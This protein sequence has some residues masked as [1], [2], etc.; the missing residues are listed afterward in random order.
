MTAE[1]RGSSGYGHE[2]A[3]RKLLF[4]R[5]HLLDAARVEME[6]FPASALPSEVTGN[7][8]ADNISIRLR[9][10][11]SLNPPAISPQLLVQPICA[12]LV[13]SK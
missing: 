5:A 4:M 2:S 3:G 1:I 7:R 9:P 10:N 12:S 13:S 11:L 6:K 8:H